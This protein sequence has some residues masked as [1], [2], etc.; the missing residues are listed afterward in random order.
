MLTLKT[1]ESLQPDSILWDHGKGAVTGFG[2]RRQKGDAATYVLKYRTTAAGRQRWHTIGR[3]GAPRTPDMAR[4][5]ARRLL[6]EV[7]N[8]GDPAG[9]K[10]DER[11]AATFG[12]LCDDYL[13][14]AK[15]GRTLTRHRAAKKASTLATDAS[16]ICRYIRPLLGHLKVASVTRLD[17]ERIL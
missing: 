12:D 11:K 7:A 4:A 14:A 15:A 13:E 9:R 5:A 6:V 1:I 2:V 17:I 10:Q 3:H 8:G 16:R